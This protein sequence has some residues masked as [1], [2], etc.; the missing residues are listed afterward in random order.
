MLQIVKF[1][2]AQIG[3]SEYRT[4]E[5][6][7]AFDTLNRVIALSELARAFKS[8]KKPMKSL[9]I[10][11]RVHHKSDVEDI[12]RKVLDLLNQLFP[13]NS[14]YMMD[15]TEESGQSIFDN[16]KHLPIVTE[17]V[18][19]YTSWDEV[20]EAMQGD[21][22]GGFSQHMS[23]PI[24][25]GAYMNNFDEKAWNFFNNY[26]GWQV[27]YPEFG[28]G[29]RVSL[30]RVYKRI[31]NSKDIR[32]DRSFIEAVCMDTGLVFFDWNPYSDEPDD[33]PFAW[34]YD[35]LIQLAGQWQKAKKIVDRIEHNYQVGKDPEQLKLL[36]QAFQAC[37][38]KDGNR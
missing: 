2:N 29:E 18:G 16:V 25:V 14:D 4:F 17:F 24:F 10:D 8:L 13:I 31:E 32:F 35:T 6:Q 5:P 30:K 19:W 22:Y 28:D 34:N 36:L 3:L 7:K 37:E 20:H 23:V 21:D 1:K 33:F 27:P 26:F 15:Y 38:V 9:S 12:D 11:I